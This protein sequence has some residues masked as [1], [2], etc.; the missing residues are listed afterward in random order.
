VLALPLSDAATSGIEGERSTSPTTVD[1]MSDQPPPRTVTLVL[2]GP[3]GVV[4]GSLPPFEAETPWWMDIAPVVS[5]V[6]DQHGIEVS[7]L[8]LLHTELP[9]AHGGAVSYLAEVSDSD[10]RVLSSLYRWEGK[11]LDDP[12]R[13]SYAKVGGPAKDLAWATEVLSAQSIILIGRPQQIRTWNLSSI[14]KLP[15]MAGPVWLKVVPPF[16]AHESDV[17]AALAAAGCHAVPTILGHDGARLLLANIA[18]TDRYEAD[19]GERCVMIDLLVNVQ[20]D[21]LNRV[22]QLVAL[23]L[24]DWRDAAISDAIANL[25]ER[26]QADVALHDW[27]TLSSFMDG[28]DA[29]LAAIERCGIPASIVHGDYHPGNVCGEP[30]DHLVMI[31]WG[32]SGIGHPLL[33]QPAMLRSSEPEDAPKLRAHWSSAWRSAVPGSDPDRAARLLAPIAAMRQALIYQR[34]LDGIEISEHPY[35]AA[36]VPDWLRNCTNLLKA[37]AATK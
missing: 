6:R 20:R 35:H 27:L 12:K 9:S 8:R 26:R 30:P 23:G 14:W 24:P 28:L 29:R 16:F 21:W 18:G 36:D 15:T 13:L 34:F 10:A 7:V 2:V 1:A 33:D 4:L 31:D 25:V 19:L 3:N 5:T 17:I 37:E 11:L 32:D 22:D